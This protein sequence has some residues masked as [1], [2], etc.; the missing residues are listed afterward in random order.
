MAGLISQ[1]AFTFRC[2]GCGNCC[3]DT[4]ITCTD[5][6]VRRLVEGTG[7]AVRDIVRFA[8]RDEVEFDKRHPYWVRFGREK[9]VM[10]LRRRGRSCGFLDADDR[11]RVYAHRPLVC[12]E[13]PFETSLST[14]GGLWGFR[15]ARVPDC[16][17][18]WD[19]DVSRRDVLSLAR[20]HDRESD[21]YAT[22]VRDWNHTFRGAGRPADF[23]HHLG[24]GA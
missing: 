20:L 10:V 6:D 5:A 19:G 9:R 14:T 4:F 21:A 22:K 7:S 16:R 2:T 15:L 1:R 17:H 23:L 8:T 3:R 12:R 24:F 18:E 13:H 11:C